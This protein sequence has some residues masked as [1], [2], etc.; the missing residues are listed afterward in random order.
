MDH[1]ESA[2]K[3]STGSISADV[4]E[5]LQTIALP[6]PKHERGKSVHAALQKRKTNRSI[7]DKNLSLQ[8][9]SNLLW[10]ACGVNR[11]KGRKRPINRNFCRQ[12]AVARF[13]SKR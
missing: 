13:M 8:M 5:G 11:K 9:L 2:K 4:V 12:A 10:S 6:K 3:Q 7:S 1:R